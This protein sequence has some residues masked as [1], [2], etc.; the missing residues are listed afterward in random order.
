MIR[1]ALATPMDAAW[2]LMG[3]CTAV[4]AVRTGIGPADIGAAAL[5]GIA[6][7]SAG[8]ERRQQGRTAPR[9]HPGWPAGCR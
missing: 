7:T 4:D 8:A 9:P 3:A 2:S 6:L 1:A 5:E